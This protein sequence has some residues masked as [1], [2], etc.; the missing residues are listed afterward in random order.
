MIKNKKG[1]NVNIFSPTFIIGIILFITFLIFLNKGGV[2]VIETITNLLK[3]IPM[4]GWAIIGV[5]LIL[6][7]TKKSGG[8]RRRR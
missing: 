2:S 7:L 8:R 5:I 4:Y 1:L 6:L 3:S